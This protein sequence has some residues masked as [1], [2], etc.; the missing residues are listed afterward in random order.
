MQ[1]VLFATI[2]VLSVYI[3]VVAYRLF[4]AAI[5]C[6]KKQLFQPQLVRLILGTSM[7]G[8]SELRNHCVEH[9]EFCVEPIRVDHSHAGTLPVPVVTKHQPLM[10]SPIKNYYPTNS[11]VSG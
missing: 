6:S 5:S 8:L 9:S 2:G 1:F 4:A 10:Q 3:W 11:G 7:C